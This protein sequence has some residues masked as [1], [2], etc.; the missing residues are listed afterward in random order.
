MRLK[1][2]HSIAICCCLAILLCLPLA[3]ATA[4]TRR[5]RMI[6]STKWLAGQLKNREVIVLQ[7]GASRESYDEGHIPGARFVPFSE[8]VMPR[9]GVLNELPPVEKLSALFTRL[10]VGDRARMVIYGDLNGLAATRTFFTLD[11]LGQADRAAILDGGL[12]KWKAE[13]RPLEKTAPTYQPG[14]FTP[15][16]N[17]SLVV[18]LETMRDLSWVAT[19]IDDSNILIIDSRSPDVYAGSAEKKTGHIPGAVNWFWMDHLSGTTVRTMKPIAGLRKI[20]ASLGVRPER[21]IVTYCNSGMQSSH[22]YFTLRYLG[23]DALVYDA[24]MPEWSK[25]PGALIISGP[26]RK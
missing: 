19:N 17:P 8:I 21:R 18:K 6:V 20:Y 26:A 3:Q 9:D 16:L 11:Y 24:S 2:D 23:V 7:V 4:G 12:E 5:T 25:A 22:T 15:R 13:G 1:I 10:G 14:G